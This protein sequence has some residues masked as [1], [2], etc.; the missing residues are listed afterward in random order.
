MC[1]TEAVNLKDFGGISEFRDKWGGAI[2]R[3]G[4]IDCL[5]KIL[6]DKIYFGEE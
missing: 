6:P 4:N 1:D 5:L 3:E 2:K